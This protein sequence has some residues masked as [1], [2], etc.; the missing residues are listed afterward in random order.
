VSGEELEKEMMF[1]RWA[2]AFLFL[3][4]I[5]TCPRSRASDFP[6]ITP[7]ELKMTSIPEQPGAPAVILDREEIDNDLLN[8]ET[9]HERIKILTEAGRQYA[10][11][12]IPYRKRGFTIRG[13]S[14]QTVHA[15]G[16]VVRFQGKSFDKT[17]IKGG[18][19]KVNVKTFTLPD[20][21]V[22]S[23][24]E[25]RYDL[26]YDD[27]MLLPPTWEV[28]N[29]L[30]QR[31]A[32]FKFIPF[33][34]H[35]GMEIILPHGQIGNGV[36]WTPF[37]GAG[38][39][40]EL[41]HNLSN[42]SSMTVGQ[43]SL[44][45]DLSLTDIPALVEEPYMP[46]ASMLRWRVY[47][48]YQESLNQAEY[49]KNQGKFW[50]KDVESFLGKDKGIGAA[51]R[52]IVAPSDTPEQKVRKIY[53]FV[54][55]LENQ[56]YIPERTEQENKV[57][58]LKQNKGSEDVLQNRS[59]SHDDLNRLFVSMVRT[60]GIPATLIWVPDRSRE[61]FLKQYLSTRQFDAEIA[62]VQ[63]DG[64]D[65]F[66]DPGTKFCPY[67]IL[68]WRYSAVQGLRLNAKGAEFGE[69]AGPSYQQSVTTRMAKVSLDPNGTA[70]GE[71]VLVF[72]G[73]AAMQKRQEAGKTDA[74][75]R[76]KMLED[77]LRSILPGNSEIALSNQP[78]WTH[79]DSPL[80]CQ[81][82]VSFPLAVLSGKRLLI[83]Q[84]LFQ[85][86]EKNRFPATQRINAIYFHSPWQEA[87][88]VHIT[89]PSGMEV[90][91]LAPDDAMK[92]DFGL[93]QVRQK[94]EGTG[95]MF[96]RRDLIMAGAVFTP[97]QYFRVK[98]FFDKVKADDDQPALVKVGANAAGSQ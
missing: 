77:D 92:L 65:L 27:R 11:V 86:D 70:H 61:I 17:V 29:D 56:D 98:G 72:K 75:G 55:Q 60:A 67:G 53:E 52:Q 26:S 15:D 96:S 3:F 39:K 44:W 93:Y 46:P 20:V 23:I 58:Q 47:F 4:V 43:V 78:D 57:L 94:Q 9:V 33:Q 80:V 16:S 90:E 51:L 74:E 21:Q 12:E 68:D 88:E 45:I 66:L 91:S 2:V 31:K 81:F 5:F 69:T 89:I 6:P 87:D 73:I 30:Y 97:D 83:Q 59:G 8:V 18:G 41:H 14:G 35:G 13:I 85:V 19:F 28:Q 42:E 24:I 79:Q 49:W 50:A 34:N 95:T 22:G 48:Y 63:I 76:K 1:A 38:A 62:I 25:Y 7:E 54:S 10:D 84:H 32:Y 40:P 64:K 37:L 71:V 82:N 36:S